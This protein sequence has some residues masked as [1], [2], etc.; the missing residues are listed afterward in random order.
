MRVLIFN[1]SNVEG[2]SQFVMRELVHSYEAWASASDTF[3]YT[4]IVWKEGDDYYQSNHPSRTK[5]FDLDNLPITAPVT[6]TI[7]MHIFKGH[8]H[9]SL[10][11][12]PPLPPTDSF[13][14]RPAILLD[15]CE[16]DKYELRTPGADLV[17]EAM[18]YEVLK[19]HPHP[20]I[21]M[22]YGCVR[23]GDY[24]TDICL[25]KYECRLMDTVWK[26]DPTLNTAA[27]LDGISKGVQFLHETLSLVHNDINPAN[28]MLD[29][30]GDPVIID[31]DSCLVP[32]GEEIGGRKGG[33]PGWTVEPMPT[34][35][36]PENDI[37]GI[38][39]IGEFLKGNRT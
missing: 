25:K 5:P 35:S 6:V 19:Q 24:L 2:Y 14:K 20:G 10:T 23:D 4:V 21:C 26:G 36:L 33:T 15:G 8:W 16:S 3:E 30:A 11:E 34:I 12:I 1:G 17:A 27:I 13:L 29:D 18:V 7:P 28:I 39:Q 31:F 37:Y 22:Y 38:T 32:I 9:P